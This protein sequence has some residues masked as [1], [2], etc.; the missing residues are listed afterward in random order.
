MKPKIIDSSF[1]DREIAR[2]Q[3]H[4]NKLEEAN[5]DLAERAISVERLE[6]L[7]AWALDR[8]L[9]YY[10]HNKANGLF[11]DKLGVM[12][13]CVVPTPEEVLVLADKF[14]QY[15]YGKHYAE[16]L[17][18]FQERDLVTEGNA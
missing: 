17:E 8:A 18:K 5:R 4:I 3:E 1:H 15:T 13:T 16:T 12:Q 6:K 14:C 10:Q 7:R 2:A 11:D 9:N